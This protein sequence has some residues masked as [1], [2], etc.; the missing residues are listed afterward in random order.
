ML[1]HTYGSMIRLGFQWF[2]AQYRD[3]IFF[4][5]TI[6]FFYL[7]WIFSYTEMKQPRVY[8]RFLL[9]LMQRLFSWR[10]CSPC[11]LVLLWKQETRGHPYLQ[12]QW[13]LFSSDQRVASQNVGKSKLCSG[14]GSALFALSPCALPSNVAALYLMVTVSVINLKACSHAVAVEIQ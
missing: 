6:F 13:Y 1:M 7:W 10:M 8:M 9:Q 4:F 12:Q 3:E 2:M 14:L 5:F 11:H